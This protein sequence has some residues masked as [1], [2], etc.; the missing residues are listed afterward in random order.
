[1][2]VSVFG[3]TAH[4]FDPAKMKLPFAQEINRA[5]SELPQSVALIMIEHDIEYPLEVWDRFA[6]YVIRTPGR[7]HAA[8]YLLPKFERPEGTGLVWVHRNTGHAKKL[9]QM[10]E[11]MKQ[12]I[13]TSASEIIL[14]IVF[15]AWVQGGERESDY[16]GLGYTY[17]PRPIW[18]TIYPNVKNVDWKML[19]TR[20]SEECQVLGERALLHWDCIVNHTRIE[21]HDFDKG[22]MEPPPMGEAPKR[23]A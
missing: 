2:A 16:F 1:M 7:I 4:R 15:P 14:D 19:D 6:T 21:F 11:H 10:N 9:V 18:Q 23:V 22:P 13:P 17:I 8:P 3:A 12:L 5:Y 20:I